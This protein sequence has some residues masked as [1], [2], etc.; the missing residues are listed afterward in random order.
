MSVVV[1][2]VQEAVSASIRRASVTSSSSG[3]SEVSKSVF[4]S[5]T[6]PDENEGS[7]EENEYTR[8]G[9]QART[10]HGEE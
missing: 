1:R 3:L 6:V 8:L 7:F 2:A 4:A 5:K 9:S 10:E